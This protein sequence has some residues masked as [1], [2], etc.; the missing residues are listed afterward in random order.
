[1]S[2]LSSGSH[3]RVLAGDEGGDAATA[4]PAPLEPP[5]GDLGDVTPAY[6]DAATAEPAPCQIHPR[7][8]STTASEDTRITP[9]R[10]RTHTWRNNLMAV[11]ALAKH[12]NPSII[13]V[14]NAGGVEG[15]GK[16][17]DSR[18]EHL[19]KIWAARRLHRATLVPP[20]SGGCAADFGEKARSCSRSGTRC[21]AASRCPATGGGR[22]TGTWWRRTR[23]AMRRWD[24]LIKTD[25]HT[26][27]CTRTHT[28]QQ[29]LSSPPPRRACYF[30]LIK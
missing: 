25:L 26:R 6:A 12:I 7:G 13:R 9:T 4:K 14:L 17:G 3:A 5:E 21:A 24:C 22:S 20:A 23:R 1:M 30:I 29:L 18:A 16:S 2:T 11:A 28:P 10:L 8:I 27:T 15:E 19:K